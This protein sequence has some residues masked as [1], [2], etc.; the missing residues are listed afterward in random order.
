M[1]PVAWTL[2]LA[3]VL[4]LTAC[5]PREV[6]L[7]GERFDTRADLSASEPVEGA[8]PLVDTTNL[9]ANRAEPVGL[10]PVQGN[11]DWP[12]RAG[13]VRHLPPHA[14]LSGA[15][16]RVWTA[17]VGAG[18]SRRSRISAAPVVA[19]GRV[20]TIDAESRVTA[21]STGGAVL[22]S[23]PLTPDFDGTVLSGGGLA[24]GEGRLFAT[25]SYGEIVA[26]D[27]ASG[28]VAWR[29]RLTS[30]ITGA[31]AVDGGVVY[32][33]GRDSSGWAVRAD[34]GRVLWTVPGTPT[35]SGMLAS[36]APAVAGATVMFPFAS[37]E[38]SAVERETGTPQ[39]TSTVAG[40]RRGRAYAGVSE[41]TG[42]PV[43]A[44]AVTYV[45][46]QSGRTMAVETETGKRL[47]TARDG[48]YGPVLVVGGAVYL[49]N[50]EARLVRLDAATGDT[51]WSVEMPY[52]LK[53]KPRKRQEI[54]AH[55][56]PVLA[57]GR[58]VVVSGDGLVRLFNPVDGTMTA[59]AEI[60]G[61]AASQP[62]L[63]G[64]LLF[65][66]GAKG[67]LHAFR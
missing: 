35:A 64:G 52:F 65:V 37:G 48:A 25:T 4:L 30:T 56:G 22:W 38:V 45:G 28:A 36:S 20:F 51:V 9:V 6:V 14:S 43:V 27:P 67:Q 59:T 10:P 44:G 49:V 34:T 41:I 60:P 29:Q 12:Q 57:G 19:G 17:D 55:F 21:V 5:A 24:F 8:A 66:L 40:E 1:R 15:P 46:N 47:W 7:E 63:A 31:P 42:D 62:A 16:V 53:D 58:L 26:L 13:N 3:G 39:W 54:T 50:D 11:A 33:V 23:V 32:A 18:N 2:G 61:G